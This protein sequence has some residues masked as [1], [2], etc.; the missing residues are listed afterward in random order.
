MSVVV[1]DCL[2][3]GL[4][5]MP[6][7]DIFWTLTR[8]WEV[9]SPSPCPPG[10]PLLT[11]PADK[12]MGS[13]SSHHCKTLVPKEAPRLVG[14]CHQGPRLIRVLSTDVQQ[15]RFPSS[16]LVHWPVYSPPIPL[17]RHWET[18]L[19]TLLSLGGA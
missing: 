11:L 3:L 12:W 19:S 17:A 9:S 10:T 6:Y 5:L 18:G 1:T 2:V 15:D 4:A 16:L 14:G 13:R 7:V 8:T